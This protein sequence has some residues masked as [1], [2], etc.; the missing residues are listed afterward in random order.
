M[1]SKRSAKPKHPAPEPQPPL[2]VGRPSR[3]VVTLV[4]LSFTLVF[5]A[6][7][8]WSYTRTSATFDEPGSLVAGYAALAS[9]DYRPAIEHPPLTRLWEALPLLAMGGVSFDGRVFDRARPEVVAFQGPFETGHRFLYKDAG[10]PSAP[11]GGDRLLY[12]AR[13]MTVLLGVL[14]GVLVY[15]WVAEWLGFRAAVVAL[16]LYT[17]EPNIAA[18]SSLVTTDLGVTCFIFGAIYFAWRISRQ[19]T[20]WNITGL[21]VCFVLAMLSKFSAAILGPVLPL[22]LAMIA[23]RRGTLSMPA[24]AS[25]VGLLIVATWLGVWAAYGF[26]YAPSASPEWLF[27]LHNH[28]AVQ[29]AV[30]TIAPLVGWIDAHH[31]LPNAFS[32]GFLHGQG[33]VQGR[34]SFLAGS[35]SNFGW[36]YYFPVAFL[37]KT[38]LA[39]LA[40]FFIGVVLCVRR[41]RLLAMDGEAFV[42]VPIAVF[43]AVAMTSSLNIGLRHILPI[44]PFV[45]VVA[46]WGAT[47]LVDST[48]KHGP[49]ICAALLAGGLLEFA[50]VYPNNLAFFNRAVG[51]PSNGF[52]YLADSNIDWGQDLKPLKGWMDRNHVTHI[53]LAYFGVA[54]PAY[55][56]IDCTYLGG[57]TIPGV[58]P[59]MM[60]P[61]R[62]PGYV[63]VS[64]TLLDGVP[65]AERDRDFYKP[66]RDRTPAADIGGSIRVYLVDRPWW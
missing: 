12:R 20:A 62:L 25:L 38:P 45:I 66:L 51:G 57:T 28:P 5:V 46:V 18:H 11:A 59:A 37:L 24:V 15:S 31:L 7:Q 53:N 58:T 32:E 52:R 44:Y 3:A 48:S 19:L 55:Y 13:F 9:G 6:L 10:V 34:P 56:G 33:L 36:W 17:I 39:L 50:S 23:W 65:F 47:A 14:L 29:R 40:L 63:A 54:D 2:S 49:R 22:L 64:V 8:V 16:G 60:R 26:R 30:P 41:G 21:V 61:P 35:Y 4:L 1:K 43:L 42:V 27:A